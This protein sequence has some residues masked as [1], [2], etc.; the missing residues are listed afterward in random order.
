MNYNNII[1]SLF[2]VISIAVFILNL[3]NLGYLEISIKYMK[4]GLLIFSI[5]IISTLFLSDKAKE[6]TRKKGKK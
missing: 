4:I 2:I 6:K 3:Y 1:L 5:S